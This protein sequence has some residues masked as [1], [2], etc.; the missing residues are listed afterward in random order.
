MAYDVDLAGRIRAVLRG[1]QGMT[2]KSM[3]GGLAFLVD[4]HMAVAAI[5]NG[6]LM[7]R[8]DPAE[9]ASLLD[10]PQ[11]RRFEMRG[12]Q[13]DGWMQV[14]A[15]VIDEDADLRR[16]VTTGLAYARTLPPK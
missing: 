3:F 10:E 13:L 15:E 9:S 8:V 2:E 7:V 12:R 14:A 4:G 1:Q 16:W 11:V 5:S 6:G